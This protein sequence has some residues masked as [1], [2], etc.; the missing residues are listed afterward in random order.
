LRGVDDEEEEEEGIGRDMM[1]WRWMRSIGQCLSSAPSRTHGPRPC[2]EV[3]EKKEG[4]T[5]YIPPARRI[6]PP[7]P[8]PGLLL[9][10]TNPSHL[11]LIISNR[12]MLVLPYSPLFQ[13]LRV[14]SRY[15]VGLAS[16]ISI[17][18]SDL[19]SPTR[20]P[21][22]LSLAALDSHN[23]LLVHP[24]LPVHPPRI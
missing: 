14:V 20:S 13:V 21:C 18:F 19:L 9:R 2:D 7:L 17:P 10:T 3:D 6:L 4:H 15:V 16:I 22:S 8:L 5:I 11:D 23:T 24:L 12:P 1:E